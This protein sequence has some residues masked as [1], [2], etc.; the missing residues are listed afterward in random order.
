MTKAA[1]NKCGGAGKEKRYRS[2]QEAMPMKHSSHLWNQHPGSEKRRRKIAKG[3]VIL[4]YCYTGKS[5][6]THYYLWE[7][8]PIS[9]DF[10]AGDTV[11]CSFERHNTYVREGR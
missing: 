3:T 9:V 5:S 6:S 2:V 11:K 4:L 1:W 7:E 8:T 10:G